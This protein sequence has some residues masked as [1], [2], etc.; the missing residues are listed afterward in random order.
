MFDIRALLFLWQYVL[1]VV[2]GGYAALS[3]YLGKCGF[4]GYGF[5]AARN[6][7]KNL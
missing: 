3:F 2:C 5:L 1:F 4:I 7:T 6:R